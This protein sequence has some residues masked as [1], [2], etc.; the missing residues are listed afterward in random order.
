MIESCFL[1]DRRT[2][3]E[4][5]VDIVIESAV[6][7]YPIRVGIEC[8]DHGRPATVQWVEQMCGKHRDLPTDKLVLVSRS[9]FCKSALRKAEAYGVEALSL[10]QASN[11]DWNHAI[12]NL[13]E[14]L[15]EVVQSRQNIFGLMRDTGG[16]LQSRPISRDE[17]IFSEDRRV[18]ATAGQLVDQI[19]LRPDV[20]RV[21]LEKMHADQQTTADF[22][23]DFEF[24]TPA[25]FMDAS[26]VSKL[27][28]IRIGLTAERSTT[29]VPLTRGWLKDARVGFGE[30]KNDAGRLMVAILEPKGRAPEVHIIQ[31]REGI[32]QALVNVDQETGAPPTTSTPDAGRQES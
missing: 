29:Q 13:R 20:G 30:G 10:D 8:V 26:G 22:F 7:T 1:S 5:E 25:F 18:S 9:G 32:E 14:I 2:G 24:P 17:S 11:L 12:A 21:F 6:G 16:T 19:M 31:S 15:V 28:G 4:R 3:E 23:I 27:E